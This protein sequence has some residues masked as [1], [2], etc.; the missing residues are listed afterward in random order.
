[1]IFPDF[2]KENDL[3]IIAPSARFVTEA[4][5]RPVKEFLE[6][7]NFRVMYADGLF[8]RHHQFAGEDEFRASV[9]QQALDHKEAKAILIARGGYGT[10]RI[11]DKLNF[12]GFRKYP[13]W[14]CGFSDITV[15]HSR[16]QR[17]GFCSLH[18]PL[19]STFLQDLESAEKTIQILKGECKEIYFACR[20]LRNFESMQGILTGGN[21][22]VLYSLTGSK[23]EPDYKKKI[24]FIED[25]DEYLY[26]IDRML[27]ALQRSGKFAHLSGILLGDFTDM[28]DHE[29][30]FGETVEEMIV[31]ITEE[32]SLPVL[33]GIPSGH[34]KK[35][36]PIILGAETRIEIVNNSAYLKY[37]IN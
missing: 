30:P 36:I 24:L 13:K 16:I 10:V 28:K 31:K 14:V 12:T 20:I 9:L 5:M 7:R 3:I 11:I 18:A 19:A 33:S 29:I 2:L 21:L 26:H 34:G 35:N 23:D 32:Y 6:S 8:A 17:E 25:V 15:L 27:R 22:S 1:M 4:T 37:L